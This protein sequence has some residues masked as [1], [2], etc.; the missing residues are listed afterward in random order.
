MLV[1]YLCPALLVDGAVP[2]QDGGDNGQLGGAAV[3]HPH[4]A[5]LQTQHE[6]A[7]GGKRGQLR[8]PALPR[9]PPRP[10]PGLSPAHSDSKLTNRGWQRSE[11]CV[12]F[13]FS[14]RTLGGLGPD[15]PAGIFG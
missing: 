15:C 7:A 13:V 11:Q 1:W 8:L 12:V 6:V 9:S 4:P 14:A 10:A 5:V 2:L 3:D